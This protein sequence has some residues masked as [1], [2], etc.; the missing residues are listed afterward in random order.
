MCDLKIG[1]K[2]RICPV[3]YITNHDRDSGKGPFIGTDWHFSSTLRTGQMIT[4]YSQ[5]VR[6]N[7]MH[8]ARRLSYHTT[9]VLHNDMNNPIAAGSPENSSLASFVSRL[10]HLMQNHG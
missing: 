1:S 9:G 7:V 2:L 6:L 4:K 10:G 8:R 3:S 5:L